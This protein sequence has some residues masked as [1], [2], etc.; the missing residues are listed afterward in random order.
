MPPERY[1]R[2]CSGERPRPNKEKQQIDG[3]NVIFTNPP[4]NEGGN[5]RMSA[6][7]QIGHGFENGE[8]RKVKEGSS[9][10]SPGGM[11]TGK[12]EMVNGNDS[13]V[14]I[15]VAVERTGSADEEF[16]G[17]DKQEVEEGAKEEGQEQVRA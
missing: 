13:V 15:V 12:G 6:G 11:T 14:L 9:K 8:P 3:H 5:S 2:E 7:F 16:D 4:T 17:G 1:P 10:K